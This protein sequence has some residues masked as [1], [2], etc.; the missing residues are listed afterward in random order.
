[1]Q[2]AKADRALVVPAG[3]TVAQLLGA[4][5]TQVPPGDVDALE[6]AVRGLLDDGAAR[7][8]LSAA[9]AAE[10]STW[11]SVEGAVDQIAAAYTHLTEAARD[12][13]GGRR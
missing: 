9:A 3:G 1:M 8:A 7:S 13:P 10:A 5:A 2:A 4:G 6:A 11:P 12:A